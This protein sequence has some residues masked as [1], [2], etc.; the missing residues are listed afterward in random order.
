MQLYIQCPINEI[1]AFVDCL[2]CDLDRINKWAKTNGI[3][4]N[5]KKS[6]AIL[7]SKKPTI[8]TNVPPLLVDGN[9]VDFSEK[10]RNLGV[11]FDSH[12]RWH[13]HVS[14]ICSRVYHALYLLKPLK[15]FISKELK[16]YLVRS[17]I[18]P[19]F[20]YCDL[21][22]CADLDYSAKK[23]LT[24]AYNACV[25]FICGLNIREH[26]SP[27]FGSLLGCDIHSFMKLNLLCFVYKFI[28]GVRPPYLDHLFLLARSSR[29]KNL[30]MPQCPPYLS[31]SMGVVGV[32]LWNALPRAIKEAA[33]YSAFRRRCLGH[34]SES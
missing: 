28:K 20:S 13:D 3:A 12:M 4:L 19:Y 9:S 1:P 18:I 24:V 7:F 15:H 33:S 25:R 34:L 31:T 8:L 22:F 16:Q 14:S 23:R 6:Q 26:V 29:S 27:H 11:I 2:N 17:L 5:P 30:L 32:R 10:V 21:I